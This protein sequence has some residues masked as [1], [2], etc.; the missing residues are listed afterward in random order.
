MVYGGKPST[1]CQNC[2]I[3]RIKCDEARPHCGAC[4]RTG[5]ECP[6][7]RHPLDVMLRDRTAFSRKKNAS[8]SHAAKKK[9]RSSKT[10]EPSPSSEESDTSSLDIVP[11]T[12]PQKPPT[13]T[14]DIIQPIN[15]SLHLPLEDTVTSFFFNSY[16]HL[17]RDPQFNNGF[18]ELLPRSYSNATFGSHVH[19]STL[20]VCFFS[21]AAWTGQRSLLRTSEQFFVRALPKI[22][23]AL[24]GDID[25]NLED[26]LMTVLLL[27]TY[28][29]LSALKDRKMPQKAHLRGAVALINSR[30]PKRLQSPLSTTMAYSVQTQIIRTSQGLSYPTVQTP[31]VWPLSPPVQPSVPSRLSMAATGLV[32][33]RLTWEKL[34]A[35]PEPPEKE[36]MD[37]LSKARSLDSKLLAWASSVPPHWIPI[38]ASVIPQSV[39]ETGI[40]NGRCDCYSDMWVAST[41]NSYRDSRIVAQN[42]ILGCLRFLANGRSSNDVQVAASTI[43]SLATDICGTVPYYIG[44]Q[45]R[46]FWA[47]PQKVEYPKADERP[48]NPAHQQ[49]APLLGGWFVLSYLGSL[50]SP[51][52]CLSDKQLGWIKKQTQRI[53]QIYTFGGHIGV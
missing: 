44:S 18:M 14:L 27:S 6:G 3:R 30:N 38:P 49:M 32:D 15:R 31:D 51:G 46:S 5:R 21:V 34:T 48:V 7:Y 29:E 45:Q 26:I 52:L 17:P 10:N 25:G 36:V 43:Q 1:G 13:P 2:R 19:L 35:T 9:G 42:I 8:P 41:W 16:F 47:N 28:E 20:A 4:V 23:Q 24:H 53:L 12:K 50:C 37:V 33:L 40:F 39:Q 22:R 11:A